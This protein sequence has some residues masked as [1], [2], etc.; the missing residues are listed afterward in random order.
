MWW[1]QELKA[2]SWFCLHETASSPSSW[3]WERLAIF[4][5]SGKKKRTGSLLTSVSELSFVVYSLWVCWVHHKVIPGGC[6]AG[7]FHP[8]PPSLMPAVSGVSCESPEKSLCSLLR[9]AGG[10]PDSVPPV[11]LPFYYLELQGAV[12]LLGM[13]EICV[14]FIQ[15]LSCSNDSNKLLCVIGQADQD[16]RR[17]P[18]FGC[19]SVGLISRKDSPWWE[20][21]EGRN[22]ETCGMCNLENLSLSL[23]WLHPGKEADANGSA[24]DNKL[25]WSM[26]FLYS[27]QYVLGGGGTGCIVCAYF[28]SLRR[29]TQMLKRSKEEL[30]IKEKDLQGGT[31]KAD[32]E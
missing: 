3:N 7:D 19:F 1:P 16:L 30:E 8:S 27:L 21:R 26:C 32:P 5:A 15:L 9:Q 14:G 17:P 11:P 24:W 22:E 4:V 18:K 12:V 10:F 28:W 23:T 29:A 13:S 6:W 25:S 20:E 31:V 2:L